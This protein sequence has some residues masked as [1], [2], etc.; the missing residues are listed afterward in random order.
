MVTL[1]EWALLGGFWVFSILLAAFGLYYLVIVALR[2]GQPGPRR[3]SRAAQLPFVTVQI[4][5]RNERYVVER[6]LDAVAKFSW[7]RD[8]LEVQV[9]DD[10]DDETRQIASQKVRWLREAGLDVTYLRRPDRLGHKAGALNYG[11]R[12]ARGSLIAIF[13]AD[14]V[15]P[16]DFLASAVPLL[17]TPKVACVQTRWAHLNERT[18]WLTRSI[19]LA[20][21]A[22]FAIEQAVRAR[23]GLLM[24]FN[25]TSCVWKHASLEAAGGW[26]EETLTEDLDLS[27]RTLARGETMVYLD[28]V[29]VPC[30]V[31]GEMLGFAR[32]QAR[33]AQGGAQNLRLHAKAITRSPA[34][35]GWIKTDAFFHLLHYAFQPLLLGLF[36][37]GVGFAFTGLQPHPPTSL[38]L[39]AV[40]MTGPFA[41]LA[42]GQ[43]RNRVR[44]W[45]LRLP[46]VGVLTI[47]GIGV[48]LRVSVAYLRGLAGSPSEFVRT[49]KY[50]LQGQ[51][52]SWQRSA[53]VPR[54]DLVTLVEGGLACLAAWAGWVALESGQIGLALSLT[55]FAL[56]FGT[57]SGLSILEGLFVARRSR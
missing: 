20:L 16:P 9:L 21:D 50:A 7:P 1:E 47:I 33:W 15:P 55:T 14:F 44:Y 2:I 48:C 56:G 41:L 51:T 10:S 29:L 4:P 3:P 18:S 22:H 42:D 27:L 25:A 39:A 24:S 19:A 23:Y 17:D 6:V 36:L 8:R 54:P 28:S 31:P 34:L 13:D 52:G 40:A 30:E 26:P 45:P 46:W 57:V 43:R 5:I 37:C 53:Y 35:N 32:Q 38:A 49:P 11:L 12:T